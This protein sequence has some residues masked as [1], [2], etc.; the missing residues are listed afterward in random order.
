VLA[1]AR[2]RV[3]FQAVER[4]TVEARHRFPPFFFRRLSYP[5]A[6][7][8]AYDL[9]RGPPART[10][11][12]GRG[13]WFAGDARRDFAQLAGMSERPR[14]PTRPSVGPAWLMLG[15]AFT[16]FTVSAG[17]MHSYAVYLVAF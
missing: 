10:R 6:P 14:I 17:L 9:D 7:A 4:R 1:V 5:S 12:G 13:P 11:P 8:R 16:A 3:F 2:E 15:G